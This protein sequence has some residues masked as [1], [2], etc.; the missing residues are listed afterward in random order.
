MSSD[1]VMHR[2]ESL[3]ACVRGAS[4]IDFKTA[5]TGIAAKAMRNEISNLTKSVQD[6]DTK[7]VSIPADLAPLT[8]IAPRRSTSRYSLSSTSSRA[9][10]SSAPEARSCESRLHLLYE[11]ITIRF[12]TV[13]IYLALSCPSLVLIAVLIGNGRRLRLHRGQDCAVCQA[14]LGQPEHTQQTHRLEGQRW[15]WDIHEHDQRKSA[16]QVKDDMTSVDLNTRQIEH[17]NT[18]ARVDVPSCNFS[19]ARLRRP[20]LRCESPSRRCL[21]ENAQVHH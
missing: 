17:L 14:A 20:N 13:R 16:L 3:N 1:S 9:I 18:M 2:S 5:T 4:H 6:P 11:G 12:G 19:V 10:P 7:Q 8:P 21:A 15:P